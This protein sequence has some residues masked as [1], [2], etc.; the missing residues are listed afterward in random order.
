MVGYRRPKNLRDLL[1]KA[2]CTPPKN[3]RR[4]NLRETQTKNTPLGGTTTARDTLRPMNKQSSIL[5]YMNPTIESESLLNASTSACELSDR[6]HPVPIRSK[7]LTLIANPNLLRN[8][9]IAKK[10]CNYCP[11]LNCTGTIKCHVT[12]KIFCTKKN[13]TCRSSNLIYCITCKT[14]GKQYV[15]QT[16]RTILARFQGHCGKITTYLKHRKESPMLFRQQDKDAVGTHFS[17][18]DHNG[19]EDLIISVLAFITIPPQSQA[20][21]VY[22]LKVE[23]QWIHRMRCPAPTGLNILD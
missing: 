11:M 4:E 10:K 5:T 7:S 21:L 8:R 15:G 14:C 12:G 17:A 22:R 20:A 23:K 3:S 19:T 9:C 1:V 13:I 6:T 16:K 2:D 18:A